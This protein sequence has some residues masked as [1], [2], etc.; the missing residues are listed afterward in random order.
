MFFSKRRKIAETILDKDPACKSMWEAM[1]CYPMVDALLSHARAH[2]LYL[3]GHTSLA[4]WIS[5]RSRRKTGIEIHPGATIGERLFI[6]HGMGI[7]IGETA[8]IGDDVTIYHGVTLGGRGHSKTK[9]HPTVGDRVLLGARATVLGPITI[10]DDA[11]VGAGAVVLDP[12]GKLETV[13]GI[14]AKV[15]R[16]RHLENLNKQTV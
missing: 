10:E 14:P 2:R 3:K 15:V 1:F 4:R 16:D 6:D 12:V 13:V 5:H 7:V 8:V 9:R 11:K